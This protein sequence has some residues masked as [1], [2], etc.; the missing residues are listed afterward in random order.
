MD[1]RRIHSPLRQRI[2]HIGPYAAAALVLLP[3]M[4]IEPLKVVGVWVAGKG[5]WLTGTCVVAVAYAASILVA[6][7][8]FMY[9]SPTFYERLCSQR[10]GV[11]S[12]LSEAP[13]VGFCAN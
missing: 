3:L 12:S 11:G 4:I 2:K 9:L 10:L 6:E 5:H 7:R 1:E 13:A 8:L